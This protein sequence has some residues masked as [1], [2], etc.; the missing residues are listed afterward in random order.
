MLSTKLEFLL[1][2]CRS[3]R[4]SLQGTMRSLWVPPPPHTQLAPRVPMLLGEHRLA[5]CVLQAP[6]PLAPQQPGPALAFPQVRCNLRETGTS[7]SQLVSF[8]RYYNIYIYIKYI[9][10][11]I[12]NIYIYK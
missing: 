8:R 1:I 5:H 6:T 9:L 7:R 10:Y 4:V 2:L 3:L 12:Y 11:Y